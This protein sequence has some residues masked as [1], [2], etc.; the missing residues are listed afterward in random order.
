MSLSQRLPRIIMDERERGEMRAEIQALPCELTIETLDVGDFVLSQEIG[1]E[2]KRGDDF[3]ASLMDNRLFAQAMRMKQVF[4]HSM[5]IL[6]NLPRA[7][8]R[9]GILPQSI[10]GA[11]TYLNCK[12]GISIL[13]SENSAQTALMIWS[14]AKQL[15]S[16]GIYPP[17]DLSFLAVRSD[18][19]TRWD[20]Q[21]F[22][23]GLLDVG[24]KRS[25][26]LLDLFGTPIGV[27]D[28]IRQ[29]EFIFTKTGKPK[30][31]NGPLSLC[32]GIGPKFLQNNAWLFQTLPARVK[33]ENHDLMAMIK[34]NQIKCFEENLE[35]Y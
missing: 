25:V 19:I 2:R 30:G 6:E 26:Q 23:Q 5:I 4:A 9:Q 20:Q 28:A 13:V 1:I 11:M 18:E 31:L 8:K 33:N 24:E 34:D 17:D 14:L 22:L 29:T 3:I 35:E 32:E 27:L 21:F 15:N 16:Q 12:L 7:F 10:Y